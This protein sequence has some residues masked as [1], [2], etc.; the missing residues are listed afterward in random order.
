MYITCFNNLY[1]T[2]TNGGSSSDISPYITKLQ[3]AQSDVLARLSE[4]GGKTN[5]LEL[6]SNPLL[7]GR[8]QL[9]QD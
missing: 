9:Y 7:R 2:L 6:L 5:R 3:S 8:T 1:N 4:V